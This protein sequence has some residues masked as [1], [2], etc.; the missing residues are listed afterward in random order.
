[1]SDMEVVDLVWVTVFVI[2]LIVLHLLN[3]LIVSSLRGKALGSQSIVDLVIQDTFFVVKCYGTMACMFCILG[4]F[5]CFRILLTN[6]RILLIIFCSVYVFGLICLCVNAGC[7]CIIRTLCVKN[8]TLISETIGECRV[9]MISAMVTFFC[10]FFAS[11]TCI[12][13]EDIESGSQITLLT[14]ALKPSGK[15]IS[16]YKVRLKVEKGHKNWCRLAG[17]L[18]LSILSINIIVNL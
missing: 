11:L 7:F 15:C 3:Y 8:M 18:I 10:G 14:S 4:R 12:I 5:I 6:T 17:K 9:R 2:L 1:M 16:R 13:G